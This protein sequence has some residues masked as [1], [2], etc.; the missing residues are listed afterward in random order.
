M[1]I[2]WKNVFQNCTFELNNLVNFIKNTWMTHFTIF[3]EVSP[4]YWK[5]FKNR[6][7]LHALSKQKKQLMIF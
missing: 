7:L 2:K 5:T 4:K 6:Q 3:M 1:F